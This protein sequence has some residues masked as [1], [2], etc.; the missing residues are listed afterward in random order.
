MN[1]LYDTIDNKCLFLNFL[2]LMIIKITMNIPRL[3]LIVLLSPIILILTIWD[4]G[5]MFDESD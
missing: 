5:K 2:A 1:D 3:V 4:F